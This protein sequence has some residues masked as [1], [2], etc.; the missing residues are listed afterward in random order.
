M[1]KYQTI[2]SH[3]H[4]QT[5]SALRA[6]RELTVG[7]STSAWH[8]VLYESLTCTIGL[9]PGALGLLLRK[10]LYP[11]LLGGC[12]SRLIVGRSVTLR[13]PRHI[14]I[15]DNVTIDDFA[16]LD[17]R[18]DATEGIELGNQVIINRNCEL[19]CKAGP[20]KIGAR[21]IIGSN[22][23]I[24]SLSGVEL[25]RGVLVGRNCTFSAGAYPI[26]DMATMMVDLGP[27][28]K[29]RIHIEDDVWIGT[30][31]MILGGITVGSH[32]VIG[33]GALV[34]KPVPSGAVV[35]GVPAH[36]LRWRVAKPSEATEAGTLAPTVP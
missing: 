22:S 4:D 20:I 35:G 19:K 36:L 6:Y 9:I 3:L 11:R 23:S 33:A 5:K 29:G 1:K 21:S 34:T 30:G 17:A 13:H 24:T 26:D 18:G 14:R 16:L 31:A 32:A 10:K 2:R 15:G 7:D 28:S 8:F 25:G 12:G 27:Y